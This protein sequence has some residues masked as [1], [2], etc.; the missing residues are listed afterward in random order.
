MNR[1]LSDFFI[2]TPKTN[3]DLEGFIH[4]LGPKIVKA[5]AIN[6]PFISTGFS[7]QNPVTPNSTNNWVST[8]TKGSW[9]SV[10]FPHQLIY[11]TNYSIRVNDLGCSEATCCR[12]FPRSW[13]LQ[14]RIGKTDKWTTIH[15]VDDSGFSP[16]SE[17]TVITY[18]VSSLHIF[19]RSNLQP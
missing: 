12:R 5:D 8:N 2:L 9:Y 16:E 15:Q 6:E 3:S 1:Q 13:L 10:S 18:P 7:K 14:G 11:L 19:Q 17:N 4:K